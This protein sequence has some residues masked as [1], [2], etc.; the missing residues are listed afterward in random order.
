MNAD[1]YEWS[2]LKRPVRAALLASSPL[3]ALF[4]LVGLSKGVVVFAA[5]LAFS[6]VGGFTIVG[7]LLF[8]PR[9]PWYSA[10]GGTLVLGMLI[11]LPSIYGGPALPGA[12]P[13]LGTV[14][15]TVMGIGG[16]MFVCTAVAGWI[17]F[18][19]KGT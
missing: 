4:I 10:C 14:G 5:G 9:W 13:V 3:S 18:A 19:R 11:P 12:F 16:I 2:L 8:G 6:V 1:R 7:V 15:L 17:A